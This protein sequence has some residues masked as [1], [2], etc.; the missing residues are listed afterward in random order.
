VAG[1]AVRGLKVRRP[2]TSPGKGGGVRRAPGPS[3]SAGTGSREAGSRRLAGFLPVFS[4]EPQGC[5]GRS[6][7]G[8]GP[9]VAGAP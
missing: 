7:P 1:T 5:S 9:G 8:G 2:L 3:P 6:R 4:G